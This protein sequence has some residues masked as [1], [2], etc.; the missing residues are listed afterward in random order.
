MTTSL[1]A[2][3]MGMEESPFN[4]DRLINMDRLNIFIPPNSL[5]P[6]NPLTPLN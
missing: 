6:L 3:G 4:I 2:A 1:Q 5:N